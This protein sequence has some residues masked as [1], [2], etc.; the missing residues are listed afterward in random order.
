MRHTWRW[1]GPIDRVSVR[2]AAQA[3]AH[4]IVTALHH[5][6]TGD[7][8]PVKEIIRRQEQVRAGGLE[9]EV[10]ESVPVSESIKT[11]TGPWREHIANW[12]ETLRR[13][14]AAGIRTVCYNFMPVL[15][16][17]RTD[18]RWSAR[19][20][21]KAMRFDRIDFAAFD[22]H[23]LQRPGALE[24]YDATTR[25]EAE[26]RFRG[27]T[28]ERRAALSR[29]IGAGLPGSADGYSLQ[30]LRDHLETYA[31]IDR[32]RLQRHF[33]DFLAEVTPVAERVGINICA[34]P[35]D[36]PWALLG[37]PRILSSA[38]DYAFVLREVESPANGVTFC[39]GSLGARA[40][41]DLPAMVRQLAPR[42]HFIHLRNVRRE[43][44]QTP[45]C[46][47]EDEHL[48]G[49]TDMVAV[50]AELLAEEKRR[51]AGGRADHQI[52]MR[53]DHGQE[54]L[55]DLTRGAQPGYPAI[56]RL[57]GLAELRGIERALSHATYGLG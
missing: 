27:M 52:P 5:I 38:E 47:Y 21:A 53:P 12:Q 2:D 3:G 25:E 23:L 4:G 1:F 19:H 37:L 10:V 8:W 40:A 43:E 44:L 30:Q 39:T 22:L 17:T 18:L 49:D 6:Q 29:N 57:K 33:V 34:H 54:I 20:G 35:D 42:I 32:E 31:G 7:V 48:E 24:D 51:R 9:W 13:L 11:Q 56:G 26:R 55:D 50:I 46:F 45:C 28:E 36:P 14:S 41:N 15:D 16:W